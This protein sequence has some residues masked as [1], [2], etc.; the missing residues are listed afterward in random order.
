[1]IM[2]AGKT[3]LK[4]VGEAVKKGRQEPLDTG[5]SCCP[6]VEFLLLQRSLNSTL[7]SLKL[8]QAYLDDLRESSLLRLN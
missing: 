5:W 4:F 7:K 8:I 6:Q 2:R 3:S 1:M